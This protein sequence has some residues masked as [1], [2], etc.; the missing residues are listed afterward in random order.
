[1]LHE[2]AVRTRRRTELI[3]ITDEVR[4]AA[5]ESRLPE[6]IC[7]VFVPHTTAAVTINEGADPSVARDIEE[8]LSRLVPAGEGYRHSEGN[9]DSHIKSTLVGVSVFVPIRGGDLVLGTWQAV[10]FCEF[11]GPRSR[12][13]LVDVLRAGS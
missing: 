4:A 11:D 5:R 10:F 13:C 6:G 9:A 1:M 2:I 3:D 7:H 8:R 12:R